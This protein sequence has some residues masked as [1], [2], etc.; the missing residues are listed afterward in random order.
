MLAFIT[1]SLAVFGEL[2]SA[3]AI[4][5]LGVIMVTVRLGLSVGYASS[6]DYSASM[7][8]FMLL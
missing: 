4:R 8:A 7:F 6:Q 2:P 5:T 1:A 3:A